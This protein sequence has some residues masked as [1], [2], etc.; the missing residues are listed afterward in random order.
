MNEQYEKWTKEAQKWRDELGRKLEEYSG[1]DVVVPYENVA[2]AFPSNDPHPYSFDYPL[3]NQHGL[4][5]W[6]E[7]KGYSVQLTKDMAFEEDRDTPLVR[8]T[9]R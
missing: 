3:I 7:S 1:S 6:A 5:Q 2:L 4:K 9:R 8:F